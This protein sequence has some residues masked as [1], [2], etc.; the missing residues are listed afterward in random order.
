LGRRRP[1]ALCSEADWVS[2]GDR[3]RSAAWPLVRPGPGLPAAGLP[4]PPLRF[5]RRAEG[6]PFKRKPGASPCRPIG[7]AGCVPGWSVWGPGAAIPGG[8]PT[9]RSGGTSEEAG[10]RS[11][12]A[13]KASRLAVAVD[14]D[15]K[16][17]R[18]L[19]NKTPGRQRGDGD[20]ASP[21]EQ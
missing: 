6:T 3:G 9:K 14:P 4:L 1:P 21:A 8:T 2:S 19:G 15:A 20:A 18:P 11:L 12:P 5:L 7:H 17:R 16:G 10:S 13:G